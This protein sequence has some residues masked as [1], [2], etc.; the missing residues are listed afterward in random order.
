MEFLD[1]SSL[2]AA[3]RYAVKIEQKLKQNT[4][5]FGPGNPSQQKPGK[6]GPNPKNKGQGKD[7]QYQDNQSKPQETKDTGK[8]KKD[9]GKWRDFHKNPWHNIADC[10]SKQSLVVK[11][12]ASE[13]NADSD[14][15]FFVC[16]DSSQGGL[17]RVLMQDGRVIAYISRKLRRHEENYMTHDLELLAIVYSLIVWRHYL[18]G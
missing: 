15:D 1:I 11:V 9:T 3:Y 8:T 5:Q 4:R 18:I 10:R 6:G 13:S 16:T 2:G 14:R 12:K 7:G 17:G